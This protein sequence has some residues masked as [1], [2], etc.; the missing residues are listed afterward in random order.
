MILTAPLS[1]HGRKSG[2]INQ[3]AK[4]IIK[5]PVTTKATEPQNDEYTFGRK[6]LLSCLSILLSWPH[7]ADARALVEIDALISIKN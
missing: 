2:F 1:I 7:W 3:R 5:A 6:F 4:G